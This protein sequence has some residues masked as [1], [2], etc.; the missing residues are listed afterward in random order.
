MPD[1]E[2]QVEEIV[3]HIYNGPGDEPMLY[4]V[5]WVGWDSKDNTEEPIEHLN[6]SPEILASYK[7][8]IA[9]VGVASF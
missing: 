1:G 3:G 4:K 9:A 6:N 5:K 8:H 7:V 2:Y